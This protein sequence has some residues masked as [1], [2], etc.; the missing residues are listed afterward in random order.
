MRRNRSVEVAQVAIRGAEKTAPGSHKVE[1]VIL[2]AA[3]APLAEFVKIGAGERGKDRRVRR[4]DDLGAARH[5]V[6][7]LPHECKASGDRECGLGLVEH[8]E[9]SDVFTLGHEVKERF[10]MAARVQLAT[11]VYLFQVGVKAVHGFR[12]REESFLSGTPIWYQLQKLA[13]R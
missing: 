4:Q 11:H 2:R 9:T 5:E 6:S 1:I 12:R 13:K 10:A 8:P 7:Q 3:D